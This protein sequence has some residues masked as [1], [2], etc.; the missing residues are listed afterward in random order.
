MGYE[1]F[2]LEVYESFRKHKR[3][4]KNYLLGS[5]N[6]RIGCI[7]LI[8]KLGKTK[9][10]IR[11]GEIHI[12][13]ITFNKYIYRGLRLWG[14]NNYETYADFCKYNNIRNILNL[15]ATFVIEERCKKRK[16]LS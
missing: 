11:D 6:M 9:M 4:V 2:S 15:V 5:I 12:E 1:S 3:F 10:Y 13:P 16:S 8:I 14:F 7:L